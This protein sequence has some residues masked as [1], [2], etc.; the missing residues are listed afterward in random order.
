MDI[1]RCAILSIEAPETLLRIPDA[2]L[3]CVFVNIMILDC[4]KLTR[5]NLVSNWAFSDPEL[6]GTG[7]VKVINDVEFDFDEDGMVFIPPPDPD[8]AKG[9][10]KRSGGEPS[11]GG[12]KLHA[13]ILTPTRELAIQIK[14]H[15]VAASKHTDIKTAV[16]VGG[17]APQKQVISNMRRAYFIVHPFYNK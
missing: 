11:D 10:P 2:K 3:G 6:E 7:C 13:L 9:K 15:I 16:V 4:E 8:F 14:D 1:I 17:M 5:L 12:R